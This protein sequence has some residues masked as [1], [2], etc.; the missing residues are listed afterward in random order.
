M[1]STNKT[2][3][4]NL[5]QFIETDK[6]TFLGD[7]NTDMNKIDDALEA[8]KLNGENNTNS[9]GNLQELNTQNKLN[10]VKAINE[11]N[12]N[13]KTGGDLKT[14]V[15]S[16]EVNVNDLTTGL[17]STNAKIGDLNTLNTTNK[18][19]VVRSINEIYNE[20]H[21]LFNLYNSLRNLVTWQVA[22]K[23]IGA[24]NLTLVSGSG[25]FEAS[26]IKFNYTNAKNQFRISGSV[27]L[28]QFT[29]SSMLEFNVNNTGLETFSNELRVVGYAQNNTSNIIYPLYAKVQNNKLV[30]TS[31]FSDTTPADYN[32]VFIDAVRNV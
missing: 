11:V 25:T 27:I 20:A 15:D 10:L 9:I 13:A 26:D 28:R 14:K 7:Y 5:S 19:T 18:D 22:N 4:F 8:N 24:D 21:P 16:L 6:P 1:A 30:V 17:E 29:T 32:I 12:E 23:E 2:N 3:N 31:E